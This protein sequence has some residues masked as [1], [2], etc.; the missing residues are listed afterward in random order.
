[1]LGCVMTVA[2]SFLMAPMMGAGSLLP[3]WGFLA[4][5]LLTM[6]VIYGPIGAFLPGLF[7]ARVRYTGASMAFNLGGVLGGGLTPFIALSLAQR[8]GL[9]YV[10]YY[11][12]AAG[13]ISLLALLSL[14]YR[15]E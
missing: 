5:G 14:R 2:M 1:M 8:G 9:R 7:P 12:A 13:L 4:I 11:L 3:I 15:E 6:G 10:G